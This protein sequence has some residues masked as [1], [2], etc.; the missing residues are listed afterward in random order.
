MA[1]VANLTMGQAL[2]LAPTGVLGIGPQTVCCGENWDPAVNCYPT[3]SACCYA[4]ALGARDRSCA[5]GPAAAQGVMDKMWGYA[6]K[7]TNRSRSRG[8]NGGGGDQESAASA[9]AD[10]G[11]WMV[12]A[13][14]QYDTTQWARGTRR[15]SSILSDET[16][17][18]GTG[19][20]CAQQHGIVTLSRISS[21]CRR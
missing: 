2:A 1:A 8:G 18:H 20:R 14:W 7:L 17:A 5:G 10:D 21:R 6:S 3:N 15:G 12:Q 9:G 11:M 4:P 19:R 13:H 16:R